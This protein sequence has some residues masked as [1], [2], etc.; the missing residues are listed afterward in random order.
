MILNE[1]KENWHY[2]A[3]KKLLEL[4]RRDFYCLSLLHSFETKNKLES[5][6]EV[7]K[8]KGFSIIVLPTQKMY[9]VSESNQ[10]MKSAKMPCLIYADIGSLIKK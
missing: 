3:V 1:E 9:N 2:L 10:Y 8:K 5:Y 7:C 6:E 4:L